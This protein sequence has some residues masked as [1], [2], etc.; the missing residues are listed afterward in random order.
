MQSFCRQIVIPAWPESFR[1]LLRRIPDLPKAFGIAGM[2]V[3]LSF[4]GSLWTDSNFFWGYSLRF[5]HE[6]F[7][8]SGYFGLSMM[9]PAGPQRFIRLLTV[10]RITINSRYLFNSY[11]RKHRGRMSGCFFRFQR[12]AG[13]ERQ[14]IEYEKNYASNEKSGKN[15]RHRIIG[16]ALHLLIRGIK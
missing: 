9:N 4:L 8:S 7:A 15:N 5:S 14:V 1:C 10:M 6:Q 2:T 11:S 16:Q 3:F 13:S 12:R